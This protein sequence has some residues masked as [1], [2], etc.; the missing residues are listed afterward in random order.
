MTKWYR[1]PV[2]WVYFIVLWMIASSL[3][4]DMRAKGYPYSL[5]FAM[6]VSLGWAASYMYRKWSGDYEED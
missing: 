4:S 1:S 5:R 6:G 2:F 3:N